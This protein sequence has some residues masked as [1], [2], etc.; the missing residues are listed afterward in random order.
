MLISDWHRMLYEQ[1]FGACKLVSRPNRWQKRVENLAELIEAKSIIDYGCGPAATLSAFSTIPIRNYDPAVPEYSVVPQPADLVVCL[2]VLEHVEA[3]CIDHVLEHLRSLA[4]KAV[5][6]A[7]STQESTKLLPDGTP[8]HSFVRDEEWW[9][10]KLV[11]F[12]EQMPM[13]RRKE[14]V[15]LFTC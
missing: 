13:E 6:V 4:T 3:D 8:W 5:F 14:Y 9:R 15:A 7:V 11:G 12:V 10:A 1:Y 2:H